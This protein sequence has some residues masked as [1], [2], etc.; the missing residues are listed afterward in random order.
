MIMIGGSGEPAA[1]RAAR[2]GLGFFPP[3]GDDHLV[4]VYHQECERLGREPGLV[5]A[6]SKFSM[7]QFSELAVLLAALALVITMNLVILRWIVRP[8]VALT[9]LARRVD[10]SHPGERS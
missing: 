1:K 10:L 6:P 5:L 7:V 4:E 8:L 9:S 2:F 3:L